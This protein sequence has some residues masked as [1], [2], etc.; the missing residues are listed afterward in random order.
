MYVGGY[1]GKT[2]RI[3]VVYVIYVVSVV[4]VVVYVG[5]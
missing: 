4:G 3:G 5:D 2:I 1:G